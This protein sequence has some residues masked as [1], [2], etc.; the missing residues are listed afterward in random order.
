M[1]EVVE[2][3]NHIQRRHTHRVRRWEATGHLPRHRRPRISIRRLRG[4]RPPSV[5]AASSSST[6]S[7]S[8]LG[9]HNSSNTM[10][11]SIAGNGADNCNTSTGSGSIHNN[12]H[13]QSSPSLSNDLSDLNFDPAAVIDGEG[14]GTEGLN[15]L[16]ANCVDAMELLSYLE[17]EAASSQAITSIN[18]SSSMATSSATSTAFSTSSGVTTNNSTSSSSVSDDILSLFDP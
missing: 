9:G 18:S 7:S 12:H 10:I 13:Q 2:V 1:V 4:H 3:A 15:L 17:P 8:G 5:S 6:S 11:N 14:Q 16:P